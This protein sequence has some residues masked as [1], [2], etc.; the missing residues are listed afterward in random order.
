MKRCAHCVAYDVWRS[1]ASEL[2]FSWPVTVPFWIMHVDLWS[3]GAIEDDTE[4]KGCLLN[5]MCNIS[6]FIVSSPTTDI[7][8]VRLGKLFIAEVIFYIWHVLYCGN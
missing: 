2:H 8:A 7:T 5:S 4:N 1:R 6:Q 3:S